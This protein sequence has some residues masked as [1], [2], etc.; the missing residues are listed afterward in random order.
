MVVDEF[1]GEQ[2]KLIT[3]TTM[4]EFIRRATKT[5]NNNDNNNK[6]ITVVVF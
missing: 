6:S 5:H 1:K 4:A 2:K 3:I